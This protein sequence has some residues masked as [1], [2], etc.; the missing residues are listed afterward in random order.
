MNNIFGCGILGE[1]PNDPAPVNDHY[2]KLHG[3]WNNDSL[4]KRLAFGSHTMISATCD[5]SR[6]I[7][8]TFPYRT[9]NGS[10]FKD[11]IATLSCDA[12]GNDCNY[13]SEFPSNSIEKYEVYPNHDS[14]KIE[15][16]LSQDGLADMEVL[17]FGL[18]QPSR[19][20]GE[21]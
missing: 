16:K 9:Y 14:L 20:T 18:N 13:L 12:N 8:N 5:S 2:T 15:Q 4:S 7:K 21:S 17:V 19:I 1:R 3:A 11:F 6:C 10:L